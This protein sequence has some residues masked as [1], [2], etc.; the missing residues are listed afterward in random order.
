MAT[1]PVVDTTGAQVMPMETFEFVNGEQKYRIQ[2]DIAAPP[3]SIPKPGIVKS[4]APKPQHKV[5]T[6][7]I[8]EITEGVGD[9]GPR[10]NINFSR[11]FD[12]VAQAR[13]GAG[14]YAK[15][16]VREQMA[17]KPVP[18]EPNPTT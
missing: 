1:A 8:V 4:Y 12:T 15:R 16:I 5:A 10:K 13:V 17:P 3:G 2:F 7:R 14:E 9:D 18:V 6:I 11:G